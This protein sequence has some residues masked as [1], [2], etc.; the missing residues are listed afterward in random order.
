MLLLRKN[1]FVLSV[2]LITVIAILLIRYLFP[3]SSYISKAYL[4]S[5]AGLLQVI[6]LL[7]FLAIGLADFLK[8]NNQIKDLFTLKNALIVS[9]IVSIVLSI[10]KPS[11]GYYASGV[12]VFFALL[13]FIKEK[14]IYAFNKVYFFLI[15]YALLQIIGA[16]FNG[17]KFHFPEKVYSFLIFPLAYCLFDFG[18]QTYLRLLR[19]V[20]RVLFIFICITLVFWIYNVNV[21]DAS[22]K[23]WLTTKLA[24]DGLYNTYALI[25][26]WSMYEH[27]TYISLVLL[28]GLVAGFYLYFKKDKLAY[29]SFWEMVAYSVSLLILELAYE[30]RVGL[31]S[32]VL[33][34]AVSLFY[35]MKLKSSYYKLTFFAVILFGCGFF[36]IK[37]NRFDVMLSDNVRK[38]DYTLA[39]NYIEDHL[40]WG[41]GTGKQ[42]E[43]LEY[44]EKIMK[45]I[46]KSINK[47]T[48]VHNQF[49]GETVQFGISGFVVLLVVVSG[50]VFYSFK[51]RSYLLQML[52]FVYI[53]F[54]LVEEP[55]YVQPGITRF[56]V[57][58]SL[59][60]A[61]GE[62]N[63]DRK[64]V[65]LR[66]WFSKRKPS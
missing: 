49:L 14:K 2:S 48:Y 7:I 8:T 20:F 39:V 24:V 47:K 22:L 23:S 59:F 27:P 32:A 65:D 44:Q 62:A 63:A 58:F 19:V 1:I 13:N 51:S 4:T 10:T 55:L 45:D 56:I 15:A 42:H 37:S 46:P 52:L 31:V 12:F 64:Y 54:M 30:S 38:V 28:S 41:T 61:V 50:L 6:F 66:Q 57:F 60:V 25:G 21:Y 16:C 33:L 18:K 29:V 36:L 53:L 11:I 17:S 5:T 34:I 35:Y 26:V 43:A 9:I 40:W 3:E